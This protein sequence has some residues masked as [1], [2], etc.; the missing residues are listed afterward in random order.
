MPKMK[1]SKTAA[2]RFR[3]TGTGKLRRLQSMR[4]HLF[5]KK[6]STRTRRLDGMSTCTRA[7]TKK[8]KRLLGRALSHSPERRSKGDADMAQGEARRRLEEAPQAGPRAGQG[9]LRQQ[10]PLVPGRQRA[11][12]A[13]AGSTRSATAGPAR[14][15]SAGCG[16]SA[17]TPPAG[18]TT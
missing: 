5:E 14:A 6:P 4:Q 12:H 8:I 11:G 1:T 18:C 10:E 2:K 15:S 9:L 7:T 16:S 17:S 3:K 13:L